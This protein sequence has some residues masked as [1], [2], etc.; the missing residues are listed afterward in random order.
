MRQENVEATNDETA[1]PGQVVPEGTVLVAMTGEDTAVVVGRPSDVVAAGTLVDTIPMTLLNA[2]TVGNAGMQA[3][4]AAGQMSGQL[5]R[6]TA[7]SVAAL[8]EFGPM[9]DASGA[10]LGVVRNTNG[11]FTK[12]LRF[13]AI[14]GATALAAVGP[15]LAAVALQMQ[16]Q[17]ISRQLV[18]IEQITRR[19]E[20]HQ[21]DE[22]TA[23]VN[24]DRHTLLE[25]YELLMQT[26]VI[27]DTQWSKI[28]ALTGPVGTHALQT[29]LRFQHV[30][31]G[32][33]HVREKGSE[34]RPCHERLEKLRL[35]E[36]QN[37][38][39]VID[40]WVK[41]QQ[42]AVLFEYLHVHR[43][44]TT[45]DPHLAEG[46]ASSERHAAQILGSLRELF[47][48]FDNARIEAGNGDLSSWNPLRNWINN[49]AAD[50]ALELLLL[51]DRTDDVR[52]AIHRVSDNAPEAGHLALA[53][54][55]S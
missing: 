27:S 6:L 32:L 17:Q 22:L 55:A 46:L 34:D 35:V 24:G 7:E 53:T 42:S 31:T 9:A 13:T 37:P 41:A 19:I 33:N 11:Q 36:Q 25:A 5:V 29:N 23:G 45:N 47:N 10:Y 15:A 44:I 3:L 52:S 28:A 51:K 12:V 30:I 50:L 8:R 49:K 20:Q 40:L 26:G 43:L 16:L 1:P 14:D 21:A 18:Q 2:M 48:D 38:L 4:G 39:Q 54:T